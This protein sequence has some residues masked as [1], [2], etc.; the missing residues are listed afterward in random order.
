MYEAHINHIDLM[1]KGILGGEGCPGLP[2]YF[3]IEITDT[4]LHHTNCPGT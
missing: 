1:I 4:I 2:P 3:D